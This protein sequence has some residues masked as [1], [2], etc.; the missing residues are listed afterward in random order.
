MDI[1]SSTGRKTRRFVEP[2]LEHRR[3]GA[4]RAEGPELEKLEGF[5]GRSGERGEEIL[6]GSLR[7]EAVPEHRP[8]QSPVPVHDRKVVL[9][10]PVDLVQVQPAVEVDQNIPKARE[11]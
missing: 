4:R 10:H 2:E 3:C 9:E 7:E 5:R 11:V 8:N 6:P 1:F